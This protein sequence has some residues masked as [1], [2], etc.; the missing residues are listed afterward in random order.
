MIKVPTTEGL[1]YRIADALV[2]MAPRLGGPVVKRLWQTDYEYPHTVYFDRR[3]LATWLSR[4]GFDVVDLRYL[5]EVP[6]GTAIDRLTIDSRIPGWQAYLMA[7]AIYVV[8]LVE[9]VRRRS[10]ALLVLARPHA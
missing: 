8:N 1:Y 7:P 2:R 9:A 3:S 10:D 5:P 6:R 4:H